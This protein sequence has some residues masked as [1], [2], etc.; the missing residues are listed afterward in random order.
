MLEPEIVLLEI[1][2]GQARKYGQNV[3]IT[4]TDLAKADK[5]FTQIRNE[6]R[7]Y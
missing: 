1:L 7:H 4:K 5:Q 2:N 3:Y 6:H